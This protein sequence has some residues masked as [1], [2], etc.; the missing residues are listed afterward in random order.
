[1]ARIIAQAAASLY[2]KG[3]AVNKVHL[4]PPL[5]PP[6]SPLSFLCAILDA[7]WTPQWPKPVGPSPLF[8]LSTETLRLS[9]QAE[10]ARHS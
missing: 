4:E 3:V 7:L 8:H 5:D 1:M 2:R 6:G 10:S 9:K